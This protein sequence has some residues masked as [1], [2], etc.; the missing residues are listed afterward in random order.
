[1]MLKFSGGAD[2]STMVLLFVA[3]IIAYGHMKVQN[4][5][6]ARQ[7]CVN[8][9]LKGLFGTTPMDA[10]RDTDASAHV[11]NTLSYMSNATADNPFSLVG[12]NGADSQ[13]TCSYA[14]HLNT[15][16][17]VKT[18]DGRS[19]VVNA[20]RDQ[21]DGSR[22]NAHL[23]STSPVTLVPWDQLLKRGWRMAEDSSYIFHRSAE[24]NA[25]LARRNGLFYLPTCAEP[26]TQTPLI[27]TEAVHADSGSKSSSV[28]NST[29]CPART[30]FTSG[31]SL[32]GCFARRERWK[33]TNCAQ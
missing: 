3:P 7:I 5:Y 13:M 29:V 32:L 23:A 10:I 22:R 2:L 24:A 11:T 31:M 25:Y 19:I 4:S 14:G 15:Y 9:V 6:S 20:N 28:S 18:F 16:L 1:M 12:V 30:T 17:S 21:N 26:R 27:T 8:S 33:R